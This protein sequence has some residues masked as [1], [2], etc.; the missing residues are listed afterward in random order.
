[1]QMR[2][3]ALM[4]LV[5]LFV[6]A[7]KP[8]AQ[9]IAEDP[10]IPMP[11][12]QDNG[13]GTETA[14]VSTNQPA[15]NST[16]MVNPVPPPTSQ[17]ARDKSGPSGAIKLPSTARQVCY[18]FYSE[19]ATPAA[20]VLWRAIGDGTKFDPK[21][22]RER[23]SLQ[24]GASLKGVY[25]LQT[26]YH[27]QKLSLTAQ[28]AGH[29]FDLLQSGT[30]G[31]ALAGDATWKAKVI[32]SLKDVEYDAERSKELKKLAAQRARD[33]RKTTKSTSKAQDAK[34]VTPAK[35][36]PV[37]KATA[38]HKTRTATASVK[39]GHANKTTKL[40]ACR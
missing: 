12:I 25:A 27:V 21:E 2:A 13:P 29:V 6:V 17:P 40:L 35:T 34:S 3:L 7:G 33:A 30:D 11:I 4:M 22:V 18:L 1:M 23:I 14:L 20:V 8:Q 39:I 15:G 37:V 5:A 19:N 28:E 9:P 36:K 32:S 38:T 31:K 16:V 26:D 24:G 10:V